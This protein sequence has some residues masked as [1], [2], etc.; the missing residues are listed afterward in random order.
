VQPNELFLNRNSAFWAYTKL[1]SEKL[2][3]SKDGVVRK[4]TR[5][6][7]LNKLNQLNIV[8]EPSLLSDVLGY[9]DYRANLLNYTVKDKLMD[10]HTARNEFNKLHAL[11]KANH[12][13]CNL[14]FNKQ[15]GEKKDFAYFTGIIN[16]LTEKTLR[17]YTEENGLIY[18][19]DLQ[20]DDNPLNLSYLTDSQGKLQGILSRRFDGAFPSTVNP[21][22]IWEVKEYYYTTTFGSRIADGVYETQLDGYELNNIAK[23][24]NKLIKHVYFIDDFNTWWNMGKSYLCRIIDMLH[25]GLVDE[26]IFGKEALERWPALIKEILLLYEVAYKEA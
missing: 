11:H 20:F 6:E 10:V 25:M 18:G 7:V 15:K 4:Y 19:R 23:E 9:L 26:V 13:T 2:N 5:T 24:T 12:F 14:P 22:A 21:V 1:I 16:I 8:I 17:E 3:Y